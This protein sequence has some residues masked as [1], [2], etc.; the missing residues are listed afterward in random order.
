MKQ[1]RAERS[2]RP[3]LPASPASPTWQGSLAWLVWLG[4]LACFVLPAR[5]FAV[6]ALSAP[7]PRGGAAPAT[8]HPAV[9]GG[10]AGSA[11]ASE[12]GAVVLWWV[13]GAGTGAQGQAAA[14]ARE[15]RR[16]VAE[17]MDELEA[18]VSAARGEAPQGGPGSQ[19]AFWSGA[20]ALQRSLAD[21]DGALASGDARVFS[22]LD[23]VQRSLVGLQVAC[24]RAAARP[25]ARGDGETGV[26]I[27]T[28]ST[29]GEEST[30]RM[31]ALADTL[32][33]LSGTYGREAA[34]TQL[35]GGLSAE[36]AQQLQRITRAARRWRPQ[37]AALAAAA[38]Q[39]GDSALQSELARLDALLQQLA[40]DQ[41]L[42]LA[43]YLAAIQASNQAL[44]LWAGNAAYLEP[45]EQ[46]AWQQADAGA[47]DLTTAADTG[48][49][50]G[51]DL[52]G[53]TA[54]TYVEGT[55]AGDGGD[56]GAA[57]G[58]PSAGGGPAG[59]GSLLGGRGDGGPGEGDGAP[60]E[61]GIG[62]GEAAADPGEMS[63]G[64]M[65]RD[66]G[67]P[68]AGAAGA[69]GTAGA[70]DSGWVV[71]HGG[72]DLSWQPEASVSTA[73]APLFAL[74]LGEA[75][76]GAFSPADP[77]AT[78]GADPAAGTPEALDWEELCRPWQPDAGKGSVCPV[79]ELPQADAL[80]L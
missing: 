17:A 44:A 32:R 20:G 24:R 57:A 60:G 6:A 69:A 80:D 75:Q 26:P 35:G 39:Q 4:W 10:P 2:N 45:G 37:A 54:W 27:S 28:I 29:G 68:S 41:R 58:D 31:G 53:G 19:P 22:F 67:G 61:A 38:R 33:R 8:G 78:P 18:L 21:L 7:S 48:F 55:P 15:V 64:G 59:P 76:D 5:S 52:S 50:F 42:T 74:Q 71:I 36:Q 72:T 79:T 34:R 9:G 51:A 11:S 23:E 46:Q 13:R 77:E 49:V 1:H 14:V 16:L 43:A 3:R 30:R 25:A 12:P 56:A 62:P 63:G 70:S 66:A 40:A 73:G 65:P 47:A